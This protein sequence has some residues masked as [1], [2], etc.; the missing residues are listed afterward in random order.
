MADDGGGEPKRNLITC[1]DVIDGQEYRP[2]T[3]RDVDITR[4]IGRWV[5][6]WSPTLGSYGMGGPGFFGLRL[7][8][9]ADFPEEWLVL[10]LWGACNWLTLDGQWVE[11]PPNQ[12]HIQEPLYSNYGD[13]EDWDHMKERVVGAQITNAQIEH[14]YSK[15]VLTLGLEKYTLEIPKDASCLSNYG[16]TMEPHEWNPAEDQRDAWIISHGDLEL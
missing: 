10:R 13:D 9:N 16:G 1:T 5:R 4:I 14:D 8:E 15:I 3:L 7:A 6:E 11:A 12:Y 2:K